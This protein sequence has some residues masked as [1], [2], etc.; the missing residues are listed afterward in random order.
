MSLRLMLLSA[1]PV[2][3]PVVVAAESKS[4]VDAKTSVPPSVRAAPAPSSLASSV[5]HFNQP[6][7]PRARLL[8]L[9]SLAEH[10]RKQRERMQLLSAR[11]NGQ[12][13]TRRVATHTASFALVLIDHACA[14][15]VAV[16]ALKETNENNS[17]AESKDS[18]QN[19]QVDPTVVAAAPASAAMTPSPV[20]SSPVVLS[21]DDANSEESDA[22]VDETGLDPDAISTVLSQANCSRAKAAKA[23]R[24]HNNIIDAILELIP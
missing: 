24:K 5:V 8:S 23:L 14:S 3:P 16:A 7:E 21:H 10:V 22:A 13:H 20:G 17:G 2:P 15:V 1:V 11:A 18:E 19:K 6:D 12:T 9:D 4:S